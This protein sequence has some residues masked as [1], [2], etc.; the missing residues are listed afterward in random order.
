[1]A[2]ESCSPPHEGQHVWIAVVISF[3]GL[4]D[5]RS[6]SMPSGGRCCALCVSVPMKFVQMA[7]FANRLGFSLPH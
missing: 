4:S 2:Q 7:F 1:M 3:V 6:S 5:V